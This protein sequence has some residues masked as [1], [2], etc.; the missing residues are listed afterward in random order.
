MAS[1]S[2][3]LSPFLIHNPRIL[4][5]CTPA[6]LSSVLDCETA[7]TSLKTGYSANSQDNSQTSNEGGARE[8]DPE[9]DATLCVELCVA[10]RVAFPVVLPVVLPVAL[11]VLLF[12]VPMLVS[13]EAAG[14]LA[15]VATAGVPV[16]MAD[17]LAMTDAGHVGPAP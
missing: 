13:V 9:P 10:L 2:V 3:P 6:L 7:V 15:S 8:N 14:V 5:H 17:I 16:L 12:N 11:P 1:R 4:L